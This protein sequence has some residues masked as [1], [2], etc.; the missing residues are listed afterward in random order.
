M[1][2]EMIAA[3]TM[4]SMQGVEITEAELKRLQAHARKVEDLRYPELADN[5]TF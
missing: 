5:R 1:D 4:D 3:V 2:P